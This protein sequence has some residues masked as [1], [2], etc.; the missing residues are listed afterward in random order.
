MFIPTALIRHPHES[1]LLHDPMKDSKKNYSYLSFCKIN[2]NDSSVTTTRIPS[3][4]Y[5]RHSDVFR[6]S[7]FQVNDN[8][9]TDHGQT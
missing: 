4:L 6:V 7:K 3:V 1:E 8:G 9:K 5:R 2:F